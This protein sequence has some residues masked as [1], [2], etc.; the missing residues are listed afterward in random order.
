MAGGVSGAVISAGV[1]LYVLYRQRQVRPLRTQAVLPVVVSVLGLVDLLS[2]LHSHPL[3]TG[4]A[5]VLAVLLVGDAVGLGAVRAFTVRL[6]RK[7]AV[8]FRQGP[9]SRS[10][11][12]CSGSPCT[13]G[14]WP[15]HTWTPRAS[16]STSA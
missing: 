8:V 4:Q 1:L 14:C 5:V 3:S 13:R 12:G 9:G 7:D 15:R 2:D 11:C 16:S 6:W 10:G